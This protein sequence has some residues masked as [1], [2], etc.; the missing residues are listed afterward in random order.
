MARNDPLPGEQIE[1]PR[2]LGF[3]GGAVLLVIFALLAAAPMALRAGRQPDRGSLAI[4]ALRTLTTA[5]TLYRQRDTDGDGRYV[6]GSLAELGAAGLIGPEL[7]AG[8]RTGY[9][10]KLEVVPGAAEK[11]W[12]AVAR[13]ER[14]GVDGD[15]VFFVNQDGTIWFGLKDVEVDP[16]TGAVPAGM[17]AIGR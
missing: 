2:G 1:G 5:E 7:A 4:G 10:F 8:R 11:R 17:S 12:W 3:I 9:V 14:P 16:A 13:P 15:R 6:Y